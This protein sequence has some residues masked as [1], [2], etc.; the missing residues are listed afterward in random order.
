MDE[1]CGPDEDCSFDM[2]M[3]RCECECHSTNTISS[4]KVD[5]KNKV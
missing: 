5:I 1:T 2:K 3:E 4:S